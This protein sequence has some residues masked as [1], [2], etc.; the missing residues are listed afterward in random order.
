MTISYRQKPLLSALLQSMKPDPPFEVAVCQSWLQKANVLLWKEKAILFRPFIP[1]T[2]SH[3][4][5]LLFNFKPQA[6]VFSECDRNALFVCQ[7]RGSGT[8]GG[9]LA[10]RG[11]QR[12]FSF[13]MFFTQFCWQ[14]TRHRVC[15]SV[16]ASEMIKHT[17]SLHKDTQSP[18]HFIRQ[19]RTRGPK[20][21]ACRPLAA[22]RQNYSLL[23]L[24]EIPAAES[25]R[26]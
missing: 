13:L 20:G 18:V 22:R 23:V 4:F 1:Q 12:D 26:N 10:L 9:A 6:S 17:K 25:V 14:R 5:C 3:F 8:G 16:V 11:F 19:R 15:A 7:C 21:A 24:N 2:R